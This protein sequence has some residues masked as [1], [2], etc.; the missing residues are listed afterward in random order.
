MPQSSPFTSSLTRRQLA[1]RRPRGL[2]RSPWP[3]LGAI[4]LL[5]AVALAAAL[6]LGHVAL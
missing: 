3:A 4:L 5:G 6:V 1:R 2:R